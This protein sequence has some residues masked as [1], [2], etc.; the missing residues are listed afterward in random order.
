MDQG[1]R[2]KNQAP[3]HTDYSLVSVVVSGVSAPSAGLVS[4]ASLLEV[5][6][7]DI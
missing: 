4:G 7:K 2:L 3:Q 5:W 6:N 1:A